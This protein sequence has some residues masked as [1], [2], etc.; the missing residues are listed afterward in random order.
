MSLVSDGL[1]PD[2]IISIETNSA[3]SF[4]VMMTIGSAQMETILQNTEK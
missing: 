3:I 1:F 4:M 2:T